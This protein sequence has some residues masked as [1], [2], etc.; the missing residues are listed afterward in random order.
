MDECKANPSW[1]LVNCPV[2]CEQCGV[3]CEDNNVHCE[4]WA[5]TGECSKNADYMNI[6]CAKV[7]YSTPTTHL[8]LAMQA[9]KRCTAK[10][11]VDENSQCKSWAG[12]GYC[13][14]GKYADYMKLRCKKSCKKC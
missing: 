2:A 1:M 8:I 12:K 13:K 9:C 5:Q 4:K 6:Y 3:T 11:C 14:G 7:S 10:P